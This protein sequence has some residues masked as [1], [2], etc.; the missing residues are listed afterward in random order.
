M[1]SFLFGSTV[2]LAWQTN[3]R[4]DIDLLAIQCPVTT[5]SLLRRWAKLH[6]QRE[7]PLT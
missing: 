3:S 1:T 5:T 4:L 2:Q 7:Q 6:C